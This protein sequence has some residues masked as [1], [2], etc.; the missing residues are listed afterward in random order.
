MN[1][2]QLI[3]FESTKLMKGKEG[4]FTKELL[5]RGENIQ[6]QLKNKMHAQLKNSTKCKWKHSFSH[7]CLAAGPRNIQYN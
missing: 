4:I 2:I 3:Y 5:N 1:P 7:A 6:K